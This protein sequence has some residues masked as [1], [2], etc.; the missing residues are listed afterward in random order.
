VRSAAGLICM[1]ILCHVWEWIAI[2]SF[3]TGKVQQWGCYQ[4]NDRRV[5]LT[6]HVVYYGALLAIARYF[7][8]AV[9]RGPPND[10]HLEPPGT[11]QPRQGAPHPPRPQAR[12]AADQQGRRL[13]DRECQER[14]LRRGQPDQARP[15]PPP[16]SRLARPSSCRRGSHRL[17][18]AEWRRRESS[19]TTG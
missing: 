18:Y 2:P 3:G 14:P 15:R 19:R 17:G 7:C 1:A 11:G 8:N 13:P 12:R 5:V 16:T 6:T 4:G 9:L 10:L